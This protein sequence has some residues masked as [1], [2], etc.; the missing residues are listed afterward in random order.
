MIWLEV[1]AFASLSLLSIIFGHSLE[2][3]ETGLDGGL[4]GWGIAEFFGIIFRSLPV[5]IANLILGGDITSIDD[6]WCFIWIWLVGNLV[7]KLEESFE[8]ASGSPF[9]DIPIHPAVSVGEMQEKPPAEVK[10]KGAS[11]TKKPA[12]IPE[13]FRK[14]F[15]VEDQEDDKVA[16][17]KPRDDR[18]PPLEI[19]KGG[20][21]IKPNERHINQTAGLIE[22]TLA[23][24][25]IPAKVVGFKVGPTITQFAVEP[26]YLDRPGG[27]G[28][29]QAKGACFQI[30]GLRRD[31]A[32]ALSAERLR[33]Q[34]P[35][36]GRSYVGIEVPNKKS[37]LV[38]L[39][40]LLETEA[41]HKLKSPP[42]NCAWERCFGKPCRG[43]S[44]PDASLVDCRYNWFR[45]NRCVSPQLQLA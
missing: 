42:L 33:I 38:R 37:V 10:K 1:S 41:F 27:M 29:R 15:K 4:V 22:K 11:R 7:L 12:Q 25:S 8:K 14:Q 43:R 32:L 21:S 5:G 6:I 40:P 31:L 39:K 19:L 3:A 9:D 30:S 34:A 20:E 44:Y 26:G 45:A 35:V 24:F 16:K 17:G 18:L 2:R 36:P 28:M 13:E 23:E